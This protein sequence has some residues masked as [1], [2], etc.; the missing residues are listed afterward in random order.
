MDKSNL[1]MT[2]FSCLDGTKISSG[3][4]RWHCAVPLST[5]ADITSRTVNNANVNI[6]WPD[7]MLWLSRHILDG[8]DI[9][10]CSTCLIGHQCNTRHSVTSPVHDPVTW[11]LLNTNNKLC[12]ARARGNY[13]LRNSQIKFTHAWSA[14]VRY[15]SVMCLSTT[16]SQ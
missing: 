4:R 12:V 14:L 1:I 7:W 9:I 5:E 8:Q 2:T 6:A 13:L 11:Y 3:T 10:T 15:L 16:T